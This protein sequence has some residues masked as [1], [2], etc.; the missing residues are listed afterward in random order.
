Q[1][2]A[3]EGVAGA[4][5]QQDT[6]VTAVTGLNAPTDATVGV[7]EETEEEVRRR[8]NLSLQNPSQSTTGGIFSRLANTAGVT[9]VQVYENDQPSFDA[10]RDIPAN[11][12]WCI[13]EG[14]TIENIVETIAL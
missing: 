14:G 9:D 3:I 2:G 13:V 4:E 11:T 7:D 8:R 1:Y 12:I 10:A 6:F 5:I